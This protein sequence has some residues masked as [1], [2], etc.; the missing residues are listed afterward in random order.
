MVWQLPRDLQ[1]LGQDDLCPKLLGVVG[2]APCSIGAWNSFRRPRG[3]QVWPVPEA[4]ER[5]PSRSGPLWAPTTESS[6]AAF[7]LNSFWLFVLLKKCCEGWGGAQSGRSCAS[8]AP[9][10]PV[11]H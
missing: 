10:V 3:S 6:S 1:G 5:V 7:S 4:L 11:C 9:P 8:Q 2:G